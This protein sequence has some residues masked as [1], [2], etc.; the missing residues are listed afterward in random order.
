MKLYYMTHGTFTHKKSTVYSAPLSPLYLKLDQESLLPRC[1]IGWIKDPQRLKHAFN[2][3]EKKNISFKIYNLLVFIC[4][5][6]IHQIKHFFNYLAQTEAINGGR[7]GFLQVVPMEHG[8][9]FENLRDRPV[10]HSKVFN[11]CK[12]CV[13]K[14]LTSCIF[15]ITFPFL[16]IFHEYFSSLIEACMYGQLC[17]GKSYFNEHFS[18]VKV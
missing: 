13:K 6:Q 10:V 18:Q 14:N 17:T 2:F 1:S 3:S 7:V 4:L 5:I 16:N 9:M 15:L 11:H 12:G 8:D